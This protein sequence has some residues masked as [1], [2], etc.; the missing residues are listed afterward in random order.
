MVTGNELAAY[1]RLVKRCLAIWSTTVD[2]L[3]DPLARWIFE[4]GRQ[5]D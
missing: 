5:D 3:V 1:D 2:G 4:G